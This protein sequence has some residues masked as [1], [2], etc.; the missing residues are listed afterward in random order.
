MIVVRIK[1]HMCVFGTVVVVVERY[2]GRR[3]NEIGKEIP[4]KK[5]R[6][7]DMKV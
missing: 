6:I 3:C 4:G 2:P 7:S 5:I 1:L